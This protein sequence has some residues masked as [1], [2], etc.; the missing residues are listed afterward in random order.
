M[1]F[2]QGRV[3]KENNRQFAGWAAHLEVRSVRIEDGDY[4]RYITSFDTK[5]RMTIGDGDA[6]LF[7]WIG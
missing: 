4:L 1:Q 3:G 2:G 7:D 5:T 6:P